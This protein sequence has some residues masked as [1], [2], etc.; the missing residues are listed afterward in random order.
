MTKAQ[1]VARL[2]AEYPT[3]K[4]GDDERGYTELSKAEYELT[5]SEW[6]DNELAS[7]LAAAKAE[8]DKAALL[9][10]LGITSE[11]AALLLS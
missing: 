2:K 6:A 10:K 4:V 3:L 8:S 1:I 9:I 5:I 7:E 11:E